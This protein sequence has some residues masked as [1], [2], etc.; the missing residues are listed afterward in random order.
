MALDMCK[1]IKKKFNFCQYDLCRSKYDGSEPFDY[2]ELGVYKHCFFMT[3]G[4]KMVVT[5]QPINMIAFF[6]QKE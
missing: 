3:N 2:F 1:K 4:S 5:L 6:S